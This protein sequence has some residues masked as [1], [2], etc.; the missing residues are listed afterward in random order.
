MEENSF[1][2][3]ISE[4][5]LE[6]ELSGVDS[7]IILSMVDGMEISIAVSNLNIGGDVVTG[8]LDDDTE[9]MISVDKICSLQYNPSWD[10]TKD[11][12]DLEIGE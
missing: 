12:M 6:Y 5:Y 10:F 4:L 1:W 11:D 9:M 8:M 7:Y 3:R 2:N